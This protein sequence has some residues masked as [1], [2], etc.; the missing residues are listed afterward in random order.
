M[1]EAPSE[2]GSRG[3]RFLALGER[4]CHP[5]SMATPDPFAF[6][7]QALGVGVCWRQPPGGRE[8]YYLDGPHPEWLGDHLAGAIAEARR[9][10][11]AAGLDAPSTP[12]SGMDWPAIARRARELLPLVG[13]MLGRYADGVEAGDARPVDAE[14]AA[15]G[16]DDLP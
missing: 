3:S 9:R 8:G 10:I 7:R 14:R 16:G 12:A 6:V 5:G 1:G 15:E 2:G 11:A 4:P 13:V